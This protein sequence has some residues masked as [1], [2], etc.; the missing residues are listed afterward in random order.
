M[1][2]DN[3]QIRF[4]LDVVQE[5]A[6]LVRTIQQ[7]MVSLALA[8]QD[9]SP[10]TVADFA[11]QALVA[12]RLS[13]AFPD[14]CLVGEENSADLKSSP[15]TLAQVAHFVA[16]LIPSA[17]PTNVL[18]WIDRGAQNPGDYYWTL[19]PVD[20]TK[21]FLRGGQYAI[22]LALMVDGRPEIGVLGCP[23]LAAD[24]S[25][26]MSGRGALFAAMRGTGSFALPISTPGSNQ[27]HLHRIQTTD[28]NDPCL[29]RLL[30]SFEASHTNADL[31]DGLVKHLA[32]QAETIRM[33]SQAKYAVLAAGKGEAIVRLL[34]PDRPDYKEKLWDHAAGSLVVEEA[35]GRVTDLDGKPLDF[36]A[37]RVLIH[38][39]G[40][41]VT[42]RTLHPIFLEALQRLGA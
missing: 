3:P 5:A 41:L 2:L 16:R 22:A 9:R 36:T 29:A 37:G 21:G 19:D 28:E 39:R 32:I 18:E 26:E 33:D 27:A 10:V 30:G 13:Q 35:G 38:N 6:S 24:G 20:G 8:K 15:D 34:S 14:T 25:Q 17:T 23:N 7:E 1:N 4:A 42:N 12:Y 40:L 31:M 11:A